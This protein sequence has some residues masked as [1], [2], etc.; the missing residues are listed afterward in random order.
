LIRWRRRLSS[1]VTESEPRPIPGEATVSTRV[2]DETMLQPGE[3]I[4]HYLVVRRLDGGGM[5]EVFLARDR[6]LERDVALKVLPAEYRTDPERLAHIRREAITLASL[7]HPHIATIHGFEET[8]R[9]E[10]VLVLELIE[11]KT[12]AE[13]LKQGP[14]AFSE[15]LQVCAKIAEALEAAHGRGVIHRDLKPGNVMIGPHGLTKVLD[16]GLALRDR[17]EPP[18][19]SGAPETPRIT[20]SGDG[21][22]TEPRS[23]D[24]T[25]GISSDG[26]FKEWRIAGTPGYMGP[27]QIG[28]HPLDAR[29]DI[30][31]FGCVLFECLSG[32]PAFRAATLAEM[33]GRV[34]HAEPEWSLLPERAFPGVRSLLGRCLEKN[35][36]RRLPRIREAR[37]E[38]EEVLGIR[39]AAAIRAGESEP[40][41]PHNLREP[42]TSFIGREREL[43]VCVG[44]LRETRLL[45]LIGSGGCGKTRLALHVA[46]QVRSEFPD[47]VWLVDLA[48]LS[49]DDRV[50]QALA[51]LVGVREEPGAPLVGTLARHLETRRVL[52][53]L[54]NCEHLLAASASLAATLL[55]SCPQLRVLATSRQLLGISEEHVRVVPP[56]EV[57]PAGGVVAPARVEENASVRLFAERGRMARPEFAVDERTTPAVIEICRRLDGVPLAI[58]LAAARLRVLS[59]EQIRARL[60]DCFRLL[61][62]GGKG[63]LPRHQTLLA[64]LE[65]SETLLIDEERRLMRALSVFAGGWTLDGA[66]A[67]SNPDRDPFDTLDALSQLVDKSLVMVEPDLE[68]DQRYRFLD[69]VRRFAGE[70]LAESGELAAF[71]DRHRDHFL[72]LA[73]TAETR[74]WGPE[75]SRW[76]HRLESEHENLLAALTWCAER[77]EAEPA[78]RLAGSLYRFW[79]TRGH[80]RLG[81]AALE[82]ALSLPG[83]DSSLE[84]RARALYAAAG[85]A[86]FQGDSE[87]ARARYEEA[88]AIY[89]RLGAENGVARTLIGLGM[90]ASR[91][92]DWPA[93]RSWYGRSVELYRRIGD[94]R[95]LAVALH[96]LGD[97][98]MRAGELEPARDWFEQ[99]LE[100][101]RETGNQSVT[102]VTLASLGEV[103]A[104]L[105]NLGTARRH[106]LESARLAAELKAWNSGLLA[107]DGAAELALRIGQ[108]D[109]AAKLLAAANRSR[110]AADLAAEAGAREDDERRMRLAR[111]AL[112]MGRFDRAWSEGDALS[113]EPALD[114]LRAWLENLD[115]DHDLDRS[116]GTTGG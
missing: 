21:G 105:G 43:H 77:G 48:P 17:S 100:S 41:T 91:R 12:L 15:A 3:Q 66:V 102:A 27:E 54:D 35:V 95:S 70:R 6:R 94:P 63:L 14:M 52:V 87:S 60:D 11:G 115:P 57:P 99:S 5:G 23:D 88:L 19:D 26:D 44:I 39:R 51:S 13:H 22:L 113:F 80:H 32:R 81:R 86:I 79:Y 98:E 67:V 49:D 53:V 28:G 76:L 114:Y 69:T 103:M 50:A 2:V 30:F 33:L 90:V 36:E 34:L 31:A 71:R 9:G 42:L 7:N 96:N 108:A 45:T 93:A 112:G 101:G 82:R 55:T 83:A 37:L 109:S 40:L 59:I 89:Q 4:G 47:G 61:A 68:V 24:P 38:I 16:F 8:A 106:L 72:S 20:S 84:P 10:P 110:V 75:Q 56:L 46:A 97:V 74:L 92:S 85:M 58:E 116:S 18:T 73:E 78:L 62:G 25:L 111:D 107:L 29:A 104:R 65:W 1:I 64:T